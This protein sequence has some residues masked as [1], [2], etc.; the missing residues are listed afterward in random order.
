MC[1][2]CVFY[3]SYNNKYSDDVVEYNSR[4]VIWYVLVTIH[5]GNQCYIVVY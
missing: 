2:L 1:F 3:V 5:D 4:I